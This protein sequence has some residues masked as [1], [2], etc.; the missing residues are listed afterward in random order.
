M[1]T[2]KPDSLG[3]HETSVDMV[4][5]G[6]EEVIDH[7]PILTEEEKIMEKRYVVRLILWF[8]GLFQRSSSSL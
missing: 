5:Q 2:E 3:V 6:K 1:S 8:G 4:E 7:T